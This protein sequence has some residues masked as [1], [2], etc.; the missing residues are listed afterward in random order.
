MTIFAGKSSHNILVRI[1]LHKITLLPIANDL[2]IASVVLLGLL[3]QRIVLVSL[4]I[5]KSLYVAITVDARHITPTRHDLIR[6]V[7]CLSRFIRAEWS[8]RLCLSLA[9]RALL[10]NH[11]VRVVQ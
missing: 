1:L 2:C 6:V 9:R 7:H 5:Q 10:L 3:G 11:T 8:G 4:H